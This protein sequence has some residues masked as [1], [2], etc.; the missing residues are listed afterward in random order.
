M[1]TTSSR[2][3]KTTQP[4]QVILLHATKDYCHQPALTQVKT[5]LPTTTSSSSVNYNK[6][7]VFKSGTFLLDLIFLF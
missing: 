1:N 6:K 4:K 7:R 5:P 2:P 3:L